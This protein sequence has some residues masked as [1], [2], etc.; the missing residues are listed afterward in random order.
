MKRFLNSY[1]QLVRVLF[2]CLLFV[3][4][5]TKPL[6]AQDAP[7][8]MD[9]ANAINNLWVLVAAILVFMMQLGFAMLESGFNAVKN[10]VNVLFKNVIDVCI[11]VLIFFSFGYAIMFQPAQDVA[12]EQIIKILDIGNQSYL[13]EI[14]LPYLFLQDITPRLGANFIA[15]HIDFFFQVAF[16]ATAAT[17]CSGAVAGRMR[18]WAYVVLTFVMIGIVYP[19]S[20]YWASGGWLYERGFRDFAGSLS[21]HAV[22]G[23]ASLACVLLLKARFGKFANREELTPQELRQLASHNLPLAT[24]GMFILWIGW[25]GFNVGSTLGIIGN[26]NTPQLVGL[27]A[28]NTTLAACA[29][30]A[31]VTVARQM[32]T[33]RIE[34]SMVIQGVLG[35]LVAITASCNLVEPIQSIIIGAV[36]GLLVI[37]GVYLLN[38]LKI[39]DAVGAFG[40]H[41]LCGI[42]GGIAAGLFVESISIPSQVLG[43]LVI[44][45]WSFVVVFVLLGIISR[46]ADIRVSPEVEKRGLDFFEHG[47]VAYSL[48]ESG[49]AS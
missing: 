43:S 10:T 22:G 28:L 11:G 19:T 49:D 21:V 23:F 24:L 20:G 16:A 18:P 44:P 36:A 26:D 46:F 37:V 30:A 41:G 45:A 32:A 27:I 12:P 8:N 47:E 3:F 31:L 5:W 48:N 7:T 25:Y 29:G 15:L 33:G 40:V 9:L 1:Q 38:E 42:W 4:F 35:G 39:D 2:C 34:L 14:H 17:I 6:F 13:W